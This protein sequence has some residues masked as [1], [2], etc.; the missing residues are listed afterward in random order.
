[1]VLIPNSVGPG[2]R[3]LEVGT[4]AQRERYLRSM[5]AILENALLNDYHRGLVVGATMNGQNFLVLDT[6]KILVL[7][8]VAFSISTAG[9]VAFAKLLNLFL[10]YRDRLFP[11]DIALISLAQYAFIRF[12][13]EGI[14]QI[15]G[16]VVRTPARAVGADD[17]LLH[18]GYA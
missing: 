14:R 5:T 15:K 12:L 18:P 16:F 10:R 4:E 8:A 13:L 3:L 11:G 17:S 1:M 6:I 2:E 7:G 9:G